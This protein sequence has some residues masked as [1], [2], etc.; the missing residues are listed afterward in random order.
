MFLPNND[1]LQQYA[2]DHP[3]SQESLV[4]FGVVPFDILDRQDWCAEVARIVSPLMG[5][6]YVWLPAQ[7]DPSSGL[8]PLYTVQLDRRDFEGL[9]PVELPYFQ[10]VVNQLCQP[11]QRTVLRERERVLEIHVLGDGQSLSEILNSIPS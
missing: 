2:I 7:L 10:Q 4:D 9:R 6:G 3:R 11:G 1:L 8:C 5:R